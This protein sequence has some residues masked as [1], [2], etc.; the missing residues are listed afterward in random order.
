MP[1]GTSPNLSS[2]QAMSHAYSIRFRI[3]RFFSCAENCVKSTGFNCNGVKICA[4]NSAGRPCTRLPS[5]TLM[6]SAL[7]V[8]AFL[9]MLKPVSVSIRISPS[10]APSLMIQSRSDLFVSAQR[11]ASSTEVLPAPFGPCSSSDTWP[12]SRSVMPR[13][14]LILILLLVL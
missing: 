2:T 8:L 10:S 13:M 12:S 5:L 3:S 7:A 9:S 4:R 6:A 1:F 11:M 14:F